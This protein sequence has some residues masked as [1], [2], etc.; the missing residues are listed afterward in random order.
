MSIV[1]STFQTWPKSPTEMTVEEKH[2]D[3]EGV[4]H[5]KTYSAPT[6]TDINAGLTAS[7]GRIATMLA[8]AEWEELLGNG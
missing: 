2:T 8:D 5:Y 7:A 3:S 6:G 4:D 1:S